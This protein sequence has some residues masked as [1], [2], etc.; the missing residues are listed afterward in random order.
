MPA[1]RIRITLEV[2]IPDSALADLAEE[3]LRT[4][5]DLNRLIASR[6]LEG[7]LS[8]AAKAQAAA[9]RRTRGAGSRG[10]RRSQSTRPYEVRDF[11]H[12][13]HRAPEGQKPYRGSGRPP[14]WLLDLIEEEIRSGK[15]PGTEPEDRT[16][17]TVT[18]AD[19]PAEESAVS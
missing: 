11:P 3:A 14:Q 6:Y 15:T 17:P 2:E 9:T 10:R 5:T 1:R 4:G 7:S 18:E 19:G 12:L 13:F 16:L 8:T